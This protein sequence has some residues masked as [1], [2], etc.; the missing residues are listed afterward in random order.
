MESYNGIYQGSKPGIEKKNSNFLVQGSILAAASVLTRIIGVVYRIPLTN[1][2]GDE[3]MGYYGYAFNIYNIALILSSYSLPL[4]VSKLVAARDAR[5]QY[6]NSYSVFLYSLGFAAI[7]GTLFALI[8]YF[9]ADFMATVFLKQPAAAIPLRVLAPTVLVFAVMGVLRGFFQ[10]KKTML[11]TSISQILEQVVNAIVS[12]VAAYFLMNSHSASKN[13][14]AYGAAGGTLGTFVGAIVSLIFLS[15]IFALYKPIVDKQ[16]RRDQGTFKESVP[17]LVT[18]MGVTILPVIL[19]QT[20]YQISSLLDSSVFS[21]VLAGKGV[22][23]TDRS[24][25]WGI[26]S[27]KYNLL[28]NVPIGIASSMAVAIIPSLVASREDGSNLIMKEKIHDSIKFNMLI[29]IPSA[30]GMGVLASPILRMIFQDASP[31]PALMLTIGSIAIVFYTL[32]TMTNAVLQGVNKMRLP[33]IHSVIALVIHILLLFILLKYFNLGAYALVVS[34]VAF[35]IIVSALNWVSVAKI[36]NYK[37]EIKKTF[38]IPTGCSVFM[39]GV[40]YLVYWLLYKVIN[41]NALCTVIAIVAGVI[42]YAVLLLL[43]KGVTE[44]ELIK[45]PLGRTMARVAV[46]LHLL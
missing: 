14:A 2:I 5:K 41:S 46:K 44:N 27:N 15:F 1:L 12:I 40:A 30:F 39:A 31:L 20:V 45:M 13:M 34:N 35:A 8:I 17:E 42:V 22:A 16:L 10:G 9:G 11:P 18:A 43:T 37:Q 32:S 6:K 4:A 25:L 29:A 36:L 3:G 23:E 28:V 19:S 38:L 33:I 7:V 21:Y 24:A 26:Y